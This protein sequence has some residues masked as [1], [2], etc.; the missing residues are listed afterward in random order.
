MGLVQ[1]KIEELEAQGWKY[2]STYPL[3]ITSSIES[4]LKDKLLKWY[5]D[6]LVVDDP[7]EDPWN[8]YHKHVLVKDYSDKINPNLGEFFPLTELAIHAYEPEFFAKTLPQTLE[9]LLE[10]V[11]DVFVDYKYVADDRGIVKREPCLVVYMR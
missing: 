11:D 7:D 5:R 8:N 10:E 3:Y 4:D 1:S 2:L 6:V 9:N